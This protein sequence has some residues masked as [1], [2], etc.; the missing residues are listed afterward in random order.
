MLFLQPTQ[1]TPSPPRVPPASLLTVQEVLSK[2]PRLVTL[3]KV[4]ALACKLAREAIFGDIRIANLLF[5]PSGKGVII[6]F[7]LAEE[8]GMLYPTDCC[9]KNDGIEE[10]HEKASKGKRRCFEHDIYS[11]QYTSY[12]S[13]TISLYQ[14]KRLLTTTL[15]A[16]SVSV[17]G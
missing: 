8:E 12:Q 11:L 9:S 3:S 1:A 4:V 14:K 13:D 10:R 17:T 2:Y 6:D 16:I 7:D 5:T 15:K